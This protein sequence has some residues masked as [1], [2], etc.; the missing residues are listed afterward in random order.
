LHE[1]G[2][3]SVSLTIQKLDSMAVGMLIA[4]FERTV[5]F[6]AS[7]VNINAYHQP[8]VEA[9]KKAAG[10]VI[11]LQLKILKALDSTPVDL[12][13]LAKKIGSSDLETI[14]KVCDHLAAN[15]RLHKTKAVSPFDASYS[16][17]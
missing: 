14:F 11:Q 13:A 1:N 8:G 7:L 4:L 12:P 15:G 10:N 6:Y 3:E 9:G 2:R 16:A 5:G 17:P